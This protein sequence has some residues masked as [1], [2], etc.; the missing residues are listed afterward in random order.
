LV[1]KISL[2]RFTPRVSLTEPGGHVT[3]A[4]DLCGA[5][6]APVVVESFLFQIVDPA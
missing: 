2:V 3:I 6:M 5:D 4:G 1:V